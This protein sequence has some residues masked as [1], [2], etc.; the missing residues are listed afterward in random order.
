MVAALDLGALFSAKEAWSGKS[1]FFAVEHA[2]D[3]FVFASESRD[4]VNCLKHDTCTWHGMR[5]WEARVFFD[6][7]GEEERIVRVELSLYNKG[8]A[9][10]ASMDVPALKAAIAEAAEG[11]DQFDSFGLVRNNRDPPVIHM[12]PHDLCGGR[13]ARLEFIPNAPLAVFGYRA[14]FFLG[15]RSEEG[16]HQLSIPAGG[17][18]IL[19]LEENVDP[20]ALELPG[21]LQERDRISG[22]ATD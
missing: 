9:G 8:D 18:H 22:K 4:V 1:E 12:I 6:K 20:E 5:V 21:N 10:L 16:K 13:Y 14:A 17:M 11:K 7:G 15:E 19:L 3:G 2:K